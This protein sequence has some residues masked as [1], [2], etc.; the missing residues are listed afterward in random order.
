MDVPRDIWRAEASCLDQWHLTYF[1][2]PY[3]GVWVKHSFALEQYCQALSGNKHATN[4]AERITNNTQEKHERPHTRLASQTLFMRL[5]HTPP[6]TP[7]VKLR[8]TCWPMVTADCKQ[9]LG[10][11]TQPLP[12]L[13]PILEDKQAIRWIDSIQCSHEATTETNTVHKYME[14][15]LDTIYIEFLPES[16]LTKVL[17]LPKYIN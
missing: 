16:Y 3:F 11:R 10:Y 7:L 8:K 9:L 17:F 5:I 2:G 14:G 1:Q 12:W 6:V 13:L 15:A 4:V